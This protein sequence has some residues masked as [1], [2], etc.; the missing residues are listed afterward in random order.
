MVRIGEKS[1]MLRSFGIFSSLPDK[2]IEGL[3]KSGREKTYA[4]GEFLFLQGSASDHFIVVAEGHVRVIKQTASGKEV[5]LEILGPGDPVGAVAVMDGKPFPASA[6]ALGSVRVL[7]LGKQ[8]FLSIAEKYPVF[9]RDLFRF[10]RERMRTARE[11]VTA[12]T[13][14]LVE[15]RIAGMLLRLAAREGVRGGERVALSV[16]LTRNDIARMVG[17]TVE[18]V[19]RVMSRWERECLIRSERGKPIVILDEKKLE[20]LAGSPR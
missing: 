15:Q 14:D 11:S 13:G 3:E 16:A 4:D 7:M 8:P 18:T 19:I 2:E 5:I 20:T 12:L 10:I 6:Q 17:S 1:L 9:T